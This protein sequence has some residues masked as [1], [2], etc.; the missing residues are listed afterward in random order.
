MAEILIIDDEPAI[1][2]VLGQFVNR[3]GHTTVQASTLA[4][5]LKWSQAGEFDVV[6]LDAGLPDGNGLNAIPDILT[7]PSSPEVIIFTGLGDADGAELAIRNGA[8]DYVEKANGFNDL[9]LSLTRALQ[10]RSEKKKST[11]LPVAL[12]RNNIIGHSPQIQTALDQLALSAANESPVLLLGETGTGKDLFARA[13][14]ENSRRARGPFVVVDCAA[15]PEPLAESMLFGHEK[16]AF[17][18]A[19]AAREGLIKAA[20]GGTLFLDEI[21]ELSLTLQKTFLRVLQHHSFRPLAGPREVFSDFRLAAATNR[22]LDHMVQDGRFRKDLLYRLRTLSIELPPLRE[23]QDDIRELLHHF[24][25][26]IH[27]REKREIKGYSPDFLEHLQRY[28]W[29]GN[30]REFYNSLGQAEASAHDSPTLYAKHLP[31]S[32]RISVAR[33]EVGEKSIRPA[34]AQDQPETYPK[35][36]EV[37]NAEI[38][39]V[40]KQYIEDL[41]VYV[42]G[43]IR[44]ACLASGLSRTGLYKRLKL[45]GIRRSWFEGSR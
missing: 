20:D 11:K 14:H 35:L 42:K 41:L 39:K 36:S 45:Y 17:T 38:A 2:Q 16:G 13:V 6:F 26:I 33:L 29:P 28:N 27:E 8:W 21:G 34:S 22:N 30:V 40:E 7:A 23:R 5:G 15:L 12:K 1:A 44:K 37:L 19:G 10:Y 18:G 32:I 9:T 4:E 24:L 3:L 31:E 25:G 43:D